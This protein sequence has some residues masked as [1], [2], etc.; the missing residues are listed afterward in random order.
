[1]EPPDPAVTMMLTPQSDLVSQCTLK[2]DDLWWYPFDNTSS[3]HGEW[4]SALWIVPAKLTVSALSLH[5]QAMALSN[6]DVTLES[7]R[8]YTI[9]VYTQALAI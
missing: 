5:I 7:M 4:S 1:M 8:S 3:T 6:E 2:S 9:P